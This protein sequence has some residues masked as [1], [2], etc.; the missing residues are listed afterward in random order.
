MSQTRHRTRIT[1]TLVAVALIAAACG[2]ESSDDEAAAIDVGSDAA[3]DA[4]SEPAGDGTTDT[5]DSEA[6]AAP[7]SGTLRVP[8]DY[9]TIQAAVDAAEPDSLIL[10][11]PGTYNEAVDVTTDRLVLRGL[12]RNAVVLDGRF[13]L[14]NGVRVLEAQGV[15][16]ENMT[17]RDY[18]RNGVF[19]THVDGYRGSFL[20]AER[21]GD[22]GVYAFGS[23]NGRINDSYGAGSPDAGFYIGQ[24]YPC[25]AVIDNVVSEHNGIGY[26]GTN[27]GGDLYI[28]NS[29]WRFNR[30]GIVPNSGSYEGCAP[31]RET[32]VVGNLVY[33]NTNTDSPAIANALLAQGNGIVVSG[34]LDNVIERNRVWDHTV[35]G[36]AIVPFP[37][38]DPI[39]PIPEVAPEGCVED[40]QALPDDERAALPSPTLWPSTGNR[41]V[42]N[43]VSGSGEWDIVVIIDTAGN[44]FEDNVATVTS[45]PDLQ[46]IA[47][48]DLDEIPTYGTDVGRFL[49][50][51]EEEREPGG[52]YSTYEFPPIGD[53]PG[54]DDP[55]GAPAV[56][57]VGPPTYPDVDAIALP[58]AP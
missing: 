21:N 17:L 11:A 30:V 32:T 37:E 46:E 20:T 43:D 10:I 54:M 2:S 44:C 55:E 52:D 40:A 22:Y 13:E 7:T 19:W 3:G 35:S 14:E 34:G 45:P 15:V 18:T 26:S 50:I 12:D 36:I 33:S 27:S 6:P 48:C 29:E 58:A 4:A 31:E 25:N 39:G 57:Q 38:D 1:V 47:G 24:C 28:V 49:E 5:T 16:V 53:L 8:D 41:V 9:P 23:V 51:I 42:G 56:P